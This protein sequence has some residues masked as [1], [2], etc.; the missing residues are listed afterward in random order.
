VPASYN[1]HPEFG[2]LCPT[3]RFRRPVHLVLAGLVVAGL[4]VGVL[5]ATDSSKQEMTTNRV[6][7][8]PVAAVT[9]PGMIL[10]P[11]GAQALRALSGALIRRSSTWRAS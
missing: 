11:Q 6:D 8:P 5:A 7:A 4:C 3:P 10:S 9:M 2:F 1:V